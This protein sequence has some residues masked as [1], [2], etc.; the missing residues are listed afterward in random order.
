MSG[1]EWQTKQRRVN[2]FLEQHDL[3]GVLLTQRNNF[4]WVTGG[5]D[6]HI[7]NNSPIGVASILATRDG[8]R[9][10]LAN[11]I[12]A[13]R[14]RQEELSGAGIETIDFPWYDSRAASERVREVIG[15]RKIAADS[16]NFGLSLPPLPRD[17]A[18]LRWSLVAAEIDRYR[19]G[20][21]R[22]SKAIEAA[23]RDVKPGMT[24][25]EIAGILDHH[26]HAQRLNPIVTLVAT[27]ENIERFRHPVPKDTR[28]RRTAMLVTCAEFGGLIPC[29]TRFIHFGPMSSE[30][31]AKQQAVCDIDTAV[32]LATKPG[33]TL[34]EIF[35]D[36]QEAY[37]QRGQEGQWKLHHQG[38]STGYAGREA[39]ATPCSAVRV[40]E[41]Q[42]FAW[43]PSIVG[44]KQEDTILCT[45]G[46]IE[47]L[48]AP[49]KDW[50]QVT[51]RYG[52]KELQRADV[53]VL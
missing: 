15:G 43:N 24:G 13:P 36:L 2:T 14:M 47:V 39:F 21:R 4:A 49:S 40:L 35:T 42:A 52:G 11:Q 5:R 31:K 1:D 45:A 23:C 16:E 25:H 53:L 44:A 34:G 12:E 26:I 46:E 7:A 22:A 48:T 10:C 30:R 20:S 41:N 50:P 51:G 38:G 32:N 33:R 6:N 27:D 3:E 17:F 37:A 19:D 9:V 18:E 29:V 28:I 8:V